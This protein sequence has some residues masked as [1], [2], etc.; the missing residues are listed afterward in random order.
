VLG[1]E[2]DLRVVGEAG[3]GFE[4]VRKVQELAPDVVLM[5]VR[6]P[7]LD[8]I[9]A[10]RR[11]TTTSRSRVLILTTFDVDVYAFDGLRNGASGFLLKDV[12]PEALCSAIRAV[13]EGDAVL[14]PRIT[15]EFVDR[16]DHAGAGI[17][18]KPDSVPHE[19]GT[20]TH[21]EREVLDLVSSGL[22]NAE[23]AGRLFLSE[24]TVKTHVTR[25]LSKLG[26]RDRV[27][28]VIYAYDHGLV[29]RGS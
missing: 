24:A 27:Q 11:I 17:G 3:D 2:H 12:L 20:L 29:R 8:G 1:A 9:E 28:A 13:A 25:V 16:F 14:T 7:G 19:V 5:D 4:A 23:V 22:S 6:M 18:P 26:L 21:R 10:T 15:R